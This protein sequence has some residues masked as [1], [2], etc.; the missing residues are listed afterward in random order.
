MR[1]MTIALTS[2][3]KMTELPQ[4]SDVNTGSVFGK[5]KVPRNLDVGLCCYD[6]CHKCAVSN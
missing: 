2:F 1:A 4:K 5:K 6:V 3:L